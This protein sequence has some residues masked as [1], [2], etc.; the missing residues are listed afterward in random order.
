MSEEISRKDYSGDIPRIMERFN[1]KKVHDY[2]KS[3]D[4]KWVS[5]NGYEVPEIEDLQ[6]TARRLLVSAALDESE[7]INI[8]TGGFMVYK[9]PW[10]LSLN[11]Q[12]AWA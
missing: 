4:H 9:L 5:N 12:V 10:G 6:N 3:V 8:G 1:F 7:I 2:M 11:F